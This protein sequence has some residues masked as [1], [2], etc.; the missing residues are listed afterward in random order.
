[1]VFE[2]MITKD[3]RVSLL[4]LGNEQKNSYHFITMETMSNILFKEQI[5]GSYNLPSPMVDLEVMQ[6]IENISVHL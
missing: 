4:S 5:L 6:K 3:N 1:M 2:R